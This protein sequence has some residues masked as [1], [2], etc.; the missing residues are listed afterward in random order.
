MKC[1]ELKKNYSVS[2]RPFFNLDINPASDK[3]SQRF[4]R[5]AT[6]NINSI[7]NQPYAWLFS[8]KFK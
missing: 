8:V 5:L 6:V 4:Q 7:D 3:D 1:N 2:Y